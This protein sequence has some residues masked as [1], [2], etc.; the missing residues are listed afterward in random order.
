MK[1]GV[2]SDTHDNLSNMI[3]ALE[4]FREQKI[5][6]IVHCGDLTGLEMVSHFVGFRVI[7]A[8]GNMDTASRAMVKRINKMSDD[9]FAGTIFEGKVD[10]VWIAAT[11][12]HIKGVLHNLI[13]KKKYAWIF[14]GHT[15]EKCDDLIGSTRVINPG[16][17]GGMGR[18]PRSFCTVDLVTQEVEFLS[19]I[20]GR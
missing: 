13:T 9:N 16:A 8:L 1:I 19:P 12:S 10:G 14:H 4:V 11:H 6:T 20:R 17:L 7:Y 3:A 18:E 5:S 2:L 15:H